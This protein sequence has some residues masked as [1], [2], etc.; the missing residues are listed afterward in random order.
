MTEGDRNNAKEIISNEVWEVGGPLPVAPKKMSDLVRERN[1]MLGAIK[2][3]LSEHYP[4]S[5]VPQQDKA[6]TE[7]KKTCLLEYFGS[8]RWEDVTNLKIEQLRQGYAKMK[9]EM[10]S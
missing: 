4:K 5:L 8:D 10:D 7:K 1:D 6:A 3:F 9:F 2:G